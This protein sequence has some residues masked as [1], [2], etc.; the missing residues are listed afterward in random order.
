MAKLVDD[1]PPYCYE[2]VQRWSQKPGDIFEYDK[3]GVFTSPAARCMQ[4]TIQYNH[5]GPLAK[6]C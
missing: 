3:V 5:A 2:N 6:R 1:D 4:Y